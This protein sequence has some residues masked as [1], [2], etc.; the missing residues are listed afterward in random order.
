MVI[1]LKVRKKYLLKKKDN[2]LNN[3]H[4]K[5]FYNSYFFRV[6]IYQVFSQIVL[7]KVTI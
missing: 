7:L 1:K 5:Q 2:M 6:K 3:I 4:T